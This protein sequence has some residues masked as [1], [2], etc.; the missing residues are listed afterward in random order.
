MDTSP[1][2]AHDHLR[3]TIDDEIKVSEQV[4]QQLKCRRNDVLAPISR[5]PPET[6]AEIFS[7]LPF[8]DVDYSKDI[9]YLE[10]IRVT[11]VCHR[12]REVAL[13]FPY[14]WNHINFT[15]LTPAGITEILARAKRVPLH[16]EVEITPWNK[17]RF[18]AFRTQLDAHISHTCHITISGEFQTALEQLVSPAPALVSLNLTQPFISSRYIIP[19][20]LFN[21]TA[22]NLTHLELRGCSIG[23]KSPLLKGLRTLKIWTPS[24]HTKPALEDW[25]A[26]LDEMSQLTTLLLTNATPSVSVDNPLMSEPQK[27]AILPSLTRLDIAASAKDCALALAHLVLPALISLRVTS[28]SQS[29]DGDDVRILVPYVAR[30]AHGP[31]DAAPLQT[32]LLNGESRYA[33]IIAW[34]VPDADV[35]I[36]NVI[37]LHMAVI[38][39]RLVFTVKLDNEWRNETDSA[40]FDVVLSSLPLNAISTLSAQN[41]TRLSKQVWLGHVP[42]L[43]LLKRVLLVP[44]AVRAFRK[45][46]EEDPPPKGLPRLPQLTKLILFKVSLTSLRT[47]HLRD[48]LVKRKEHG[49]P[50]EDLD[51]RT[52]IVTERAIQLLSETVGNVQS[53]AETLKVGH[54]AFFNWA[55]T[56]GPFDEE[57]R[58]DDDE[59]DD[60]PGPWYTPMCDD[61]DEEDED[62]FDDS[63]DE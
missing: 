11:R 38:S 62:E 5:L 61:E 22:P 10:R 55:S 28:R 18:N 20:F 37:G 4:T 9:T 7:L 25:L 24:A 51:L 15:I 42:R 29:W 47:Y 59:L 58:T 3:K 21:G 43:T 30:H 45:M 53:P 32:I 48:M 54:P 26:A 41:N 16:F 60:G 49:A 6:L 33:Q 19:D 46:L 39:A 8:T 56:V 63:D 27:T 14:L 13:R 35:E 31:Q 23:W 57:E 12:W 40:I 2:T 1:T 36:Y 17:A 44:T 34:T 50:L 52:C